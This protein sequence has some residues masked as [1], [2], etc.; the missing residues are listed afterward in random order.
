MP[1]VLAADYCHHLKRLTTSLEDIHISGGGFP[2]SIPKTLNSY[3]IV[4]EQ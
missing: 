4:V 3:E 2:P 1:K